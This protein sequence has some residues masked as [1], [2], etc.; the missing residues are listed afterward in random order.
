MTT[1]STTSAKT[2]DDAWTVRRILDW[3]I[4]HL[5]KHGSDTPRL[6]AE[7]LLAHARKCPRIK[8]YTEYDSVL[9]DA[10]RQLMR[11]LVRRRSKAEP[12]AYLVGHREFFGLNFTVTADVLIPR[13]D[14]ETLV[15]Q[16]LNHAKA[17]PQPR[18]LDLG[19][20]T[21]CIAVSA[22]HHLKNAVVT[23]T[24]V[25]PKALA[26]A[27]KN[28]ELNKVGDR[29]PF[30]QGDLFAAI[31]ADT[32]FEIIASNPP[33]VTTNELAALDPGVRLHEPHLALDGGD[34]GLNIVR[35]IV[36]EAPHH[37][38]SNG[39]LL[40]EIAHEQAAAVEQLLTSQGSFVDVDSV[41]DTTG[42]P[43]VV[44]G[45]MSKR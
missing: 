9:T 32:K 27:Q 25:S 43:R 23:A 8:L 38:A 45:K 3:T 14:T 41:P 28:A 15:L 20:G 18:I 42:R 24:D 26:V 39:L 31:G 36:A 33:Y 29:I 40:I 19:T 17:W 44:R 5:K 12:V 34:D 11:E 22:A 1:E 16:I 30:H 10:Q 6:D 35:R 2:S 13:P 4:P 7:I 21:G 37:L